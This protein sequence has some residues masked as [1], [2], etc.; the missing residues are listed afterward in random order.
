[1]LIVISTTRDITVS[2]LNFSDFLK[3]VSLE[4]RAVVPPP[5]SLPSD[6]LAAAAA[7]L[8]ELEAHYRLDMP[9]E[10]PPLDINAALWAAKIFYR[11]CQFAAYRYVDAATIERELS[12][13]CPSE[14][15][16]AVQYSVDLLF[17][18]LPSLLRFSK[19]AA[20][21]DVLNKCL[22]SLAQQWP[23]SSV[24]VDGA[25][26]ADLNMLVEDVS[27]RAIYVDR[28]ISTEDLSRLNDPRVADA[29]RG[30]IGLHEDLSSRV[31]AALRESCT[32]GCNQSNE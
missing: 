7:V 31:S 23:L 12:Q 2:H 3:T 11:A 24:G 9:G 19:T 4:G 20:E 13:P 30:A 16:P 5:E 14:D 18:F 27:L 25:A 15:S 1:M 6:Q 28:I 10:L 17:R 21:E 29:V 26:N 22:M 8:R 32:P